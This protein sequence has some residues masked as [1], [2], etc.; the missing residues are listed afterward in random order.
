MKDKGAKKPRRRWNFDPCLEVAH[1][2]LGA[3]EER[4]RLGLPH[5]NK[6]SLLNDIVLEH[7]KR[8]GHKLEGHLSVDGGPYYS[9][10]IQFG[11]PADPLTDAEM[12]R[13]DGARLREMIDNMSGKKS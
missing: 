9:A 8:L 7:M 6:N 13:L 5:A 10:A 11:Q 12:R 3:V 1:Y 2:I 4:E